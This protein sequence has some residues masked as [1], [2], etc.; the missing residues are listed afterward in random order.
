MMDYELQLKIK[1]APLL[2]LMRENGYQNAAELARAMG[3]SRAGI[4]NLLSL[5]RTIYGRNNWEVLSKPAKQLSEF[6]NVH[7][8]ELVPPS[9]IR[10]PL[11]QSEFT[12]QVAENQMKE[13]A[14]ATADPAKILEFMQ[15]ESRDAFED[16]LEAARIT[17]RE[18]DVLRYRE[19]DGLTLEETGR[20]MGVTR[21]RIRHIEAKALRKI[22]ER[23]QKDIL[24]ASGIYA[25]KVGL[26]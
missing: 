24:E 19:K 11:K 2:N 7:P 3:I 26:G 1:N 25:E 15:T 14:Q 21:E 17:D 9:H 8:E 22:R 5:K 13:L 4:D 18:R 10:H 20:K 23:S 6:F 12:A 16:M